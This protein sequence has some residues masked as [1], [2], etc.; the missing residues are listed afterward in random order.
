MLSAEAKALLQERRGKRCSDYVFPSPFDPTRPRG[1][2]VGAWATIKRLADLPD[3]LRPHDLRH[4]YASHAM[5]SGESL[6][7]TGKLLGHRAPQ[8][9]ER[10][11]HLDGRALY[12][13]VDQ[14]AAEIERMM[15]G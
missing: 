4:T 8:S 9:T 5:L 1:S 7:L 10:H 2:I 13:A 12:R 3:T 14:V 11:A 15:E 6:Y